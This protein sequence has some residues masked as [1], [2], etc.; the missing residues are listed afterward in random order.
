MKAKT[1]GGID[2]AKYMM[3]SVKGNVSR[4]QISRWKNRGAEISQLN[5]PTQMRLGLG[6]ALIDSV[7]RH[8]GGWFQISKSYLKGKTIWTVNVSPEMVLRLRD[9]IGAEEISHPI[10]RPTIVPPKPWKEK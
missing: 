10:R 9:V 5:W 6:T 2:V 3:A 8:S 1:D 4:R 7:V